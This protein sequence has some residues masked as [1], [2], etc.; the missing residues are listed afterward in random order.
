MKRLMA[1]PVYAEGYTGTGTTG[2]RDIHGGTHMELNIMTGAVNA[3]RDLHAS[4]IVPTPMTGTKGPAF[5]DGTR[6][7]AMG[8]SRGP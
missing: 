4:A 3:R 7:A 2:L 8:P 5:V 1:A 6:M